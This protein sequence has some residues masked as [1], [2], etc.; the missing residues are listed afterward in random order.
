MGPRAGQEP[1][2]G[3]V[4]WDGFDAQGEYRGSVWVP[5]GFEPRIWWSD[6]VIGVLENE[7]DVQFVVRYDLKP[8]GR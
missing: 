1:I 8:A 3:P 4:L 2:E 5:A 6:Q 7:L